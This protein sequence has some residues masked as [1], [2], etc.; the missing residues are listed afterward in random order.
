MNKKFEELSDGEIFKFNS[1]EY[2]KM[3]TVKI[4]CC[5]AI[6]AQQTDNNNQQTFIQ[7]Q[8]EVE[9]ND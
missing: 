1:I 9:V 5:R 2:K 4:S 7:P 3:P 6:N 8:Q